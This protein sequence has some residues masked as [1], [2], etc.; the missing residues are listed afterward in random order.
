M[1]GGECNTTH[2]RPKLSRVKQ[3]ASAAAAV[4][5]LLRKER[6]GTGVTHYVA[7]PR[8]VWTTHS[9]LGFARMSYVASTGLIYA[10]RD[11]RR[12]RLGAQ[13]LPEARQ[14]VARF[15]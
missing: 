2:L 11:K 9:G 10:V 6:Q 13:A 12:A 8:S 5:I 14:A 1:L 4:T 7:T 15:W 3:V